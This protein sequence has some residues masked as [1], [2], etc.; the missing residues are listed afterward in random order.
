MSGCDRRDQRAHELRD[1]AIASRTRR[2]WFSADDRHPNRGERIAERMQST[3][4]A[5]GRRHRRGD[6]D[7]FSLELA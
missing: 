5:L 1:I 2:N 6:R 4:T 3:A 7:D